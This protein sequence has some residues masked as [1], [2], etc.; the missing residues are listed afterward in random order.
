MNKPNGSGLGRIV[1]ATECSRKGFV[2][3]WRFEAAFRQEALLAL[4]LLPLSFWLAQSAQHWAV[5]VSVLLLVLIV[6]LL[7]SAIETLTD[8][9]SLER[10][11]LSGRAKDLGSAAVTLSLTVVA[12]V[13]GVALWQKL[14]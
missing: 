6:E 12:I 1:K 10:H 3:A 11:E 14:S 13:W 2:A 5:L 8:R 9:V 4:L 7:N